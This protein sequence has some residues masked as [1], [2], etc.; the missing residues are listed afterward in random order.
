MSIL[1]SRIVAQLDLMAESKHKTRPRRDY[2]GASVIGHPCDA[3]CAME[4][5]GWPTLKKASTIRA[6]T[7]GSV[8]EYMVIQELRDAGFI[9]TANDP[10]TGEQFEFTFPAHGGVFLCHPDGFIAVYGEDYVL[11]VKSAKHSRFTKIVN[12]GVKRAD[13]IYYDQVTAAMGLSSVHKAVFIVRDKDG[14][15]THCEILELDPFHWS[16]IQTKIDRILGGECQKISSTPEYYR[17]KQC[18][19]ARWC[20]GRGAPPV[21]TWKPQEKPPS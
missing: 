16:Y 18:D 3:Y 14:G 5:H 2:L 10:V 4:L 15:E 20:W 6:G 7:L 21:G 1:A 19:R 8:I 11:E 17:C 12:N 9:V 13:P